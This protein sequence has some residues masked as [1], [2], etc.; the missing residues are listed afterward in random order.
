MAMYVEKS[1]DSLGLLKCGYF[2]L[3]KVVDWMHILV[4][5]FVSSV[6]VLTY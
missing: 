1:H 5:I 2:L 4:W 3:D 6:Q